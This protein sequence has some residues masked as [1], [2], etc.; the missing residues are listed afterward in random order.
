MT[1]DRNMSFAKYDTR[2]NRKYVSQ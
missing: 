1:L 2:Q